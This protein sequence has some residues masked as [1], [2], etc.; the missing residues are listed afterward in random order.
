[1]TALFYDGISASGGAIWHCRCDCGREFNTY[2]CH[3]KRGVTQSCGCI[4][5]EKIADVNKNRIR[6]SWEDVHD[7]A[8]YVDE[9]REEQEKPLVDQEVCEEALKRFNQWRK[10]KQ[11]K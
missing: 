8:L 1:M 7:I 6:L 3:L 10:K 5:N 4:R 11:T 9:V 2:A